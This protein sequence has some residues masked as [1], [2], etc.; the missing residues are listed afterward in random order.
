[1][2]FNTTFNYMWWSVL[3]EEETDNPEKTT[4]P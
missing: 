2:M 3:L 1:M 4:D